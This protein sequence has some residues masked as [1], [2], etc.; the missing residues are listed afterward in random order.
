MR[1]LAVFTALLL[2]GGALYFFI[3]SRHRPPVTVHAEPVQHGPHQSAAPENTGPL[4]SDK[5][6]KTFHIE[7]TSNECVIDFELHNSSD[8][9]LHIDN[10]TGSCGCLSVGEGG[11]ELTPDQRYDLQ[12]VIKA[13][14]M[15]QKTEYIT[16]HYHD[17]N[18]QTYFKRLRIDLNGSG[19]FRLD[20]KT[21]SWRIA[22]HD[23]WETQ[24][25]TVIT[26]DYTFGIL[27]VFPDEEV[28]KHFKVQFENDARK[29]TLRIT[30]RTEQQSEAC[31]LVL[32]IQ[33]N[34]PEP[35]L[36]QIPLT[37]VKY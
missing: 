8:G 11:F 19:S 7:G 4:H 33:T 27:G 16:I 12:A 3:G 37:L 32:N 29:M 18:D 15:A 6:R 17:E 20:T 9:S 35:G 10:I 26:T 22:D 1:Y 30:P 34:H 24:E 21:L 14:A 36:N 31:I 25:A 13:S 2:L 28:K 5:D 23:T